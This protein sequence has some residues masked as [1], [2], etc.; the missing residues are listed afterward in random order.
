MNESERLQILEM[1]EKG[2][3]SASEGV[4]LLNSLQ[5]EADEAANLLVNRISES[6]TEEPEI[7]PAPEVIEQALPPEPKT[8]SPTTEFDSGVKRWRRW[9]WV[10]L[11]VGIGITVISGLLMFL[12]YQQS[13]FGFWFACLWFP[14][15]LG[16]IVISLAAAS[17]TTRWLH[18][19]IQ[20]EPG[21]WPQTIAI[22]L[23]VPIRFVAWI[24]R[25]FRSH[26]PG[27]DKTN[28]DE[29]ILALDKTSPDQPFY[30]KVDEDKSGEKV[31]VYIG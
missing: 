1:I 3:I 28:L 20:Q 12:A 17:R 16:V 19:R 2:V 5:G 24:L 26:I 10:P 18:V 29:V 25:I 9:W 15:L 22:S 8:S 6:T 14:L 27:M 21:E 4:R 11:S 23:P 30:V 31:E 7:S 13:G